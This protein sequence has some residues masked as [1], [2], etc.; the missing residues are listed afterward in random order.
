LP[1]Q[2]KFAGSDSELSMVNV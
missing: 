1:K 2:L